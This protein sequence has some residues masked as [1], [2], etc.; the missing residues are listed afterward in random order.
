MA[1]SFRNLV[2]YCSLEYSFKRI[3]LNDGLCGEI[4]DSGV[5][6]II[7][8]EWI[9][10]NYKSPILNSKHASCRHVGAQLHL[11]GIHVQL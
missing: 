10:Y 9:A 6:S 5:S 1:S 11:R 7:H 8:S 4:T 2:I 3:T